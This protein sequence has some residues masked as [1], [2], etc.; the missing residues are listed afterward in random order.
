MTE[1]WAAK[2]YVGRY[3]YVSFLGTFAKLLKATVS[4]VM[5]VRVRLSF[6]PICLRMEELGSHLADFYKI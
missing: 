1:R 6:Q 2:N 5:S 4:F 3:I